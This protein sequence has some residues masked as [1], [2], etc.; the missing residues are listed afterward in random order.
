MTAMGYEMHWIMTITWVVDGNTKQ[1]TAEG[2]LTPGP[3]ATRRILFQE[4]RDWVA[5][6]NGVDPMAVAGAFFSLAPN[7]IAGGIRPE[8]KP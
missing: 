2:V 5:S 3:E 1:S 6:E 4:I 8:E 7:S